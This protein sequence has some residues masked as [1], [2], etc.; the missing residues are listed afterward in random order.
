[1]RME[2]GRAGMGEESLT[3]FAESLDSAI[4]TVVRETHLKYYV[5]VRFF[6]K[7]RLD[8]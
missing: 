2:H 7:R 1:M 5:S 6:A 4:S 8:P 3:P